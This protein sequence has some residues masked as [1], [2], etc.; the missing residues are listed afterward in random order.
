MRELSATRTLR[1]PASSST[2]SA[3]KTE[4]GSRGASA[5]ARSQARPVPGRTN[6]MPCLL[7]GEDQLAVGG[8]AQAVVPPV[9]LPDRLAAAGGELGSPE[10]ARALGGRR[11][12]GPPL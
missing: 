5:S 4:A 7:L 12:P 11:R 2:T 8:D 6:T 10:A 9:G 1:P 3:P